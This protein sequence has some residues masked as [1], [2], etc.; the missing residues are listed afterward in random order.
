MMDDTPAL[1]QLLERR[2]NKA[3]R[4]ILGTKERL[5]PD[6]DDGMLRKV[7]LDEI[8]ELFEQVEDSISSL[9][10]GQTVMVN[11]FYLDKL[12]ELQDWFQEALKGA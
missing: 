4:A 6:D 9:Q 2:K 8:N 11:Q 3:I 5:Y 7:V 1:I 12:E 10:A